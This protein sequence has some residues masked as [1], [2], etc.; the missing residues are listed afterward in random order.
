M[1]MKAFPFDMETT[2]ENKLAK[3][4]D[5]QDLLS[6][7]EP[8]VISKSSV[9]QIVN[10]LATLVTEGFLDPVDLAIRLKALKDICEDT[11]KAIAPNV[12]TEIAKGGRAG[13][14]KHRA[15]AILKQTNVSWDFSKTE[16]WVKQ[17]AKVE[18]EKVKLKE[19]EATLKTLKTTK[20]VVDKETGEV[21]T[22]YPPAKSSSDTF[23]ISY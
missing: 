19:L 15:T 3:P 18:Q 16:A 13:I 17:S 9:Q 23:E 11:R 20:E 10:T 8:C 22:E 7:K 5:I 6:L 12:L 14:T 21:T 2:N 1:K 4:L